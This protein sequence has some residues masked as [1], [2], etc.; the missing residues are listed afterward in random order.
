MY[1]RI[2]ENDLFKKTIK[3]IEEKEKNRIFCRHGIDHC[4]DVARI[5][6]ILALEN[7]LNI[8]KD[9]IYSAALLHDTGRAFDDTDHDIK[10]AELAEQILTQCGYI[11]NIAEIKNAILN[12]R[13]NTTA[14]NNLSD[15]LSKADKLSR[16]C[17]DCKAKQKCYWSEERRNKNIKY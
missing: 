8:N 12:H 7:N 13:K 9:I 16:R 5:A 11:N 10:G 17:F 1:N 6:Y 3:A 4:L 14:L 2:I 15:I